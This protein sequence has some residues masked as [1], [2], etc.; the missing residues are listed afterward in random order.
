MMSFESL[1]HRDEWRESGSVGS[2]RSM[3]SGATLFT[4]EDE[5]YV[6]G[7]SGRDGYMIRR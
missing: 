7:G 6:V 4:Y 1:P 2:K 3:I 5:L